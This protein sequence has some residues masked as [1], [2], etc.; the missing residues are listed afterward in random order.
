[1]SEQLVCPRCGQGWV[2][3]MVV[4]ETGE[5]IQVCDECDAIWPAGVKPQVPG[6]EDLS[7]YLQSRGLDPITAPLRQRDPGLSREMARNF[8]IRDLQMKKPRTQLEADIRAA[9]G[10]PK[11]LTWVPA[12]EQYRLEQK[13]G[14]AIGHSEW[15]SLAPS[16]SHG[17]VHNFVRPPDRPM[18]HF[19][20]AP[21]LIDEL[22]YVRFGDRDDAGIA[23]STARNVEPNLIPF[24]EASNELVSLAAQN[25]ASWLLVEHKFQNY[26]VLYRYSG[27][28]WTTLLRDA[29]D[30]S[31]TE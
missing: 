31:R 13:Y 20:D 15:K 12:A 2:I 23:T 6:F 22:V 5:E 3:P 24:L 21:D 17:E 7:E 26:P 1:M 14:R 29:Q 19:A 18:V 16:T 8:L 11:V 4:E 9:S 30:M 25:F 10:D 28:L 27:Q